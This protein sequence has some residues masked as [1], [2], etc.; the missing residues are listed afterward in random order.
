MYSVQRLAVFLDGEPLLFYISRAISI[1]S[2]G[3]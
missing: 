3:E 2:T 1:S